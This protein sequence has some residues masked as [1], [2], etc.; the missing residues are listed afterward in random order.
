MG[1]VKLT[2]EQAIAIESLTSKKYIDVKFHLTNKW[3][4]P[5]FK[6]LNELSG[7][8][9]IK[10]LYV[11]YEVEPEYKSGDYVVNHHGTI[12]RIDIVEDD[13][14]HGIWFNNAKDPLMWCKKSYFQRH[15]TKKEV[16]E[17][18]KIEWWSKHNRDVWELKK[19]DLI[20]N[21]DNSIYEVFFINPDNTVI[22]EQS[23]NWIE[24]K[25]GNYQEKVSAHKK[26]LRKNWKVVCFA[27]DR[28]DV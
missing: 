3:T 27:E 25:L 10:A 11:G 26:D 21:K 13:I 15:A 6:P 7:D 1:K 16:E 18:K 24:S 8:D 14:Y 28:Q 5:I 17:A 9:F 20:K 12:G 22:L 19:G 23:G 2:K 4:S